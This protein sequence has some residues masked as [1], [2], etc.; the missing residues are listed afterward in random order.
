MVL[1]SETSR[2]LVLTHCPAPVRHWHLVQPL[3]RGS[4]AWSPIAI[5]GAHDQMGHTS[6]ISGNMPLEL[7]KIASS[8]TENSAELPAQPVL[9]EQSWWTCLRCLN[10][11]K[12]PPPVPLRWL[13]ASCI[14][15]KTL[16]KRRQGCGFWDHFL[17]FKKI[18][19][20]KKR[21][22]KLWSDLYSTNPRKPFHWPC[23]K[24]A[25]A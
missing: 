21:R 5:L 22:M 19:I 10:R 17:I 1:D 23:F 9:W 12:G 3:P 25:H 11:H 13:L 7:Q 2:R 4:S 18:K 14:K 6:V 20:K 16:S 8:S 15:I 24:A